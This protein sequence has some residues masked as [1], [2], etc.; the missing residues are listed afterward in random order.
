MYRRHYSVGGSGILRTRHL[1]VRDI[2]DAIQFIDVV[3]AFFQIKDSG[4][5]GRQVA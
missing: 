5:L 1:A 3:A 2:K 4:V